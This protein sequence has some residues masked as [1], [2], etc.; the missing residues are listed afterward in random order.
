MRGNKGLKNENSS[1]FIS[2]T[3]QT[4]LTSRT[5]FG[6]SGFVTSRVKAFSKPAL[7]QESTPLALKLPS[8][9]VR[10][11]VDGANHGISSKFRMSIGHEF[12]KPRQTGEADSASG[13]WKHRANV[14]AG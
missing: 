10:S 1:V 2:R 7:F 13:G 9:E 5:R 6:A 4:S 3:G 11:L 14:V 8:Q 12:G